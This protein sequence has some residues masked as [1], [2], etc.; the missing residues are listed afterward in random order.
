MKR[1]NEFERTWKEAI[2]DEFE[3]LT[4]FLSGAAEEN[5]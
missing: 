5:H 1:E 2:T 4:H 3:V